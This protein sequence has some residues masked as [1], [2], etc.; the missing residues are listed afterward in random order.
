MTFPGEFDQAIVAYTSDSGE[1]FTIS[2]KLT[3]AFA[4]GNTIVPT[5][6]NQG[7]PEFWNFRTITIQTVVPVTYKLYK[8]KLVIGDPNNP[9]FVGTVNTLGIDGVVWRIT[10]RKGERRRG[11]YAT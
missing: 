8:R 9:Y 10:S 6:T 7:I 2:Q 3:N 11:P 1:Q 4:V 5:R